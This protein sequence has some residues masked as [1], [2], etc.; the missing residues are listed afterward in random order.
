M[1]ELPRQIADA[2][3]G[4]ILAQTLSPGAK[5]GERELA[6]ACGTSRAVVKQALLIL[7]ETGLVET[8][9]HCGAS[10]A[11]LSIQEAYDLFEA[12]AILEQG[13]AV[14]LMRNKSPAE[15]EVLQQHVDEVQRY[16]DDN[17]HE[18]ADRH[19]PDFHT[20]FV[21]LLRNR[22]VEE[23][24]SQLVRRSTLLRML[25]FDQRH[26]R[27]RLN[28]DHQELIRLLKSGASDVVFKHIEDHYRYIVRGFDFDQAINTDCNLAEA[29]KPFLAPD[30]VQ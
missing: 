14:Q 21:K 25:C 30:S 16:I 9:N 11:K 13:V 3:T 26:H 29:L 10:V 28:E 8:R 22:A 23:L 15:W 12:I 24:H 1:A 4:A 20:G 18:A 27:C 19:G 6:E 17:N 7:S 5:L 2:V